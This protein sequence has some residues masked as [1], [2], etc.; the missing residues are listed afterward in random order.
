MQKHTLKIA[1][2]LCLSA[3]IFFLVAGSVYAQGVSAV[4]GRWIWQEVA[5]K[6]KPQTKFSLVIK[7]EGKT[8][9]GVYSVDEFINGK[10]QGEDGNQTPFR[11]RV[12]G[13]T[14]EL[15]FDPS[16]TVPGYQENVVYKA[17]EDG[18]KPSTAVLT[19]VGKNLVWRLVRGDRIENVPARVTLH[20]EPRPK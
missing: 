20:R 12:V 5:R 10:W 4:T 18:R 8:V 6:N 14:V 1:F 16:A 13:A 7:R 3:G 11:G 9:Q 19:F 15:E 2:R 17:P